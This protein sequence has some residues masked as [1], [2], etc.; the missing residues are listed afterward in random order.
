MEKIEAQYE[1]LRAEKADIEYRFSSREDT[2]LATKLLELVGEVF[3]TCKEVG[4][5]YLQAEVTI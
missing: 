5:T 4:L 2:E 3:R 1:K